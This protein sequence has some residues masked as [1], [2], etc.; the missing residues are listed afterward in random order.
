MST[1]YFCKNEQ[2]RLRVRDH[3][4]LN[5]IDFLEV[6]DRDAPEGS[7]RQ[8]TL[9]VRCL[10]PVP[11]GFTAENLRIEGGVRIKPVKVVWGAV[12]NAIPPALVNAAEKAFFLA[13]PEPDHVLVVRTDSGGDYST[14]TL[15]LVSSSTNPAPPAGFDLQLSEVAFSFK[16]ECPSDFD[17]KTSAVCPTEKLPEPEINYLA[18]DYSSFRR[19]MLDRLSVIMPQ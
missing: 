8:Q 9:L 14:Y 15:R 13:L 2:R 4:T 19:L 7:P 18:K 6:L 12:A 17:C 3:A 1:Q 16:V 10:K 11:P 5:G